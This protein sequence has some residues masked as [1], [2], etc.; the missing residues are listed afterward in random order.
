M[1]AMHLLHLAMRTVWYWRTTT[2]IKTA[3]KVGVFFIVVLLIVALA[4]TG[5]IQSE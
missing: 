2:A 5:A 3:S 4:A 1:K